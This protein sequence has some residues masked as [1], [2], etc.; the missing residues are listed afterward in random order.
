MRK[1]QGLEAHK[2]VILFHS[3]Q[4]VVSSLINIPV[5]LSK[6]RFDLKVNQS[7]SLFLSVDTSMLPTYHPF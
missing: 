1:K 2:T 7:L 6:D 3:Y 5:A 4:L